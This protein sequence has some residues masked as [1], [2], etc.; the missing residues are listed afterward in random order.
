[1]A[2]L[3]SDAGGN[4]QLWP[5]QQRVLQRALEVDAQGRLC[6]TY[7]V[8][9]T[10]R[11][12]GKSILARAVATARCH[13][14]GRFGEPQ[15][16]LHVANALRAAQ[17]IMMPAWRWATEEGLGIRKAT[18]NEK[19]IWP[20]GSQWSIQATN[21]I[22]GA[23]GGLIL[24]DEAWDLDRAEMENSTFPT[25]L[26]RTQP[27]VWML[28]TAND[29][30]TD[31]I[32]YY[33]R[34]AI[35]G[36]VD[37]MIAEWSVPPT[38]DHTDP[39][40]WRRYAAHWTDQR[41]K[42]MRAA[43]RSASFRPQYLNQWPSDVLGDPEW[44][45]GWGQCS[46]VSGGPPPG[47]VAAV[48]AG[49]DRSAWG[50]SVAVLEGDRVRVWSR[51]VGTQ[52]QAVQLLTAWQPQRVLVGLSHRDVIVGPWVVEGAGSRETYE[53][54]PV[55]AD[56]VR[57]GRVSHDGDADL[58]AQVAAARVTETERGT[59]LSGKASRGPVET[60]KV[61]AWAVWGALR[62]AVESPAIFV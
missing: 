18:G 19:I 26:Q 13:F 37:T 25:M 15:D 28:S 59:L 5:W 22:Y 35:S 3:A 30:A 11:Q 40:V 50:V 36:D 48:D 32:P 4:L 27:Q 61:T 46:R 24:A 57:R 16:V 44:P 43:M 60:L 8:V 31:F 45:P 49:R 54:T 10:G 29:A 62:P 21:S 2:W 51:R 6:W 33:R 23:S 53:A 7:V 42:F 14:A 9:S 1:M 12:S 34:Q 17:R 41:E 39:V 56:L 58:A 47:G 55:L 52:D 20:D 38:A